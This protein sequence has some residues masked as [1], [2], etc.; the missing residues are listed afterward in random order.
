MKLVAPKIDSRSFRDLLEESRALALLYTPE[1]ITGQ[2]GELGQALLN[3]YLQLQEQILRRLNRVPEK[4]FVAF[5]D[6]MGIKLLPAQSAQAAVTFT[7]ANGTT[8]HVLVPSGT[9]LSGQAA[10]GSGEVV[11]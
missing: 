4:N 5:L 2:Q 6:M 10:D 7:L 11:F 9:L 3:I 8:E 1:W